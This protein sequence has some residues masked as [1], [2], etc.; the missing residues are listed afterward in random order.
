MPVESSAPFTLG[1]PAQ[2]ETTRAPDQAEGNGKPDH[3]LRLAQ[4]G[5]RP[6]GQ[7]LHIDFCRGR[8]TVNRG[9]MAGDLLPSVRHRRR[10]EG[11]GERQDQRDEREANPNP[12]DGRP[13]I[14]NRPILAST[15]PHGTGIARPRRHS[16]RERWR[17]RRP[18]R[19]S[20]L[21]RSIGAHPVGGRDEPTL[22]YP[23]GVTAET[24]GDG[25]RRR[26]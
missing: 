20:R 19:L 2:N 8:R 6:A 3:L 22:R 18:L 26:W 1:P 9:W 25:H 17:A 5:S 23:L 7:V 11:P 12:D 10:H 13:P 16:Q 4:I 14:C 15:S 24:V 21:T